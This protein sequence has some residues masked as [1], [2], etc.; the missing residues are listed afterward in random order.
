MHG[1]DFTLLYHI[2]FKPTLRN[3]LTFVILQ[4]PERFNKTL[5]EVVDFL[6]KE[7][8][9]KGH[10]NMDELRFKERIEGTDWVKDITLSSD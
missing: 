8:H 9:R 3:K 2:F 6:Q 5:N 10:L 4:G 7:A 1:M